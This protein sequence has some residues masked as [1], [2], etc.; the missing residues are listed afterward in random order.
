MERE[1]KQHWMKNSCLKLLNNWIILLIHFGNLLM[2]AVTSCSNFSFSNQ[3]WSKWLQLKRDFFFSSSFTFSMNCQKKK[4]LLHFIV[5]HVIS[6]H[7]RQYCTNF[8]IAY[9]INYTIHKSIH[10]NG[11]DFIWKAIWPS[12]GKNALKCKIH[13]YY[14]TASSLARLRNGL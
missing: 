5:D 1:E 11:T 12:G 2:C 10:S 14:S 3:I 13:D 9:V 6:G 7:W 4:K 8:W